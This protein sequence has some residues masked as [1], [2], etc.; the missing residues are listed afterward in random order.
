M[1]VRTH[2]RC[3]GKARAGAGRANV[4]DSIARDVDGSEAAKPK[5][6]PNYVNLEVATGRGCGEFKRGF[7]F[8][9]KNSRNQGFND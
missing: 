9:Q 5:T 1:R 4:V 7:S 3:A 2:V 8:G 6:L